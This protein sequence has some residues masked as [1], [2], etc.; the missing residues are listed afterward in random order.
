MRLFLMYFAAN[1]RPKLFHDVGD[2]VIPYLCAPNTRGIP[3]GFIRMGM[4]AVR[5]NTCRKSTPE[6]LRVVR[7]RMSG[8]RARDENTAH[9]I[10]CAVPETSLARLEETRILTKQRWKHGARHEVFDCAV[11]RGRAKALPVTS[12]TLT[13][14]WLA[15]FCLANAREKSVPGI[16]NIVERAARHDLEFLP[17]GERRNLVSVLQCEKVWQS[18][19]EP[20]VRCATRLALGVFLLITLV[21]IWCWRLLRRRRVR[22]RL[23]SGRLLTLYRGS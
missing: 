10:T 6:Y 18:E 3:Q 14:A 12:R 9:C 2:R 23:L 17:R 16:L 1:V 15:I 13:I 19:E 11:G 5:G 22:R 8:I 21:L 20:V 7:L 4:I